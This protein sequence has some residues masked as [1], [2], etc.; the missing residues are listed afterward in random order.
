MAAKP[1][2]ISQFLTAF[3]IKYDA[4]KEA[5]QVPPASSS[6]YNSA[7]L[8]RIG[9][10]STAA[11]S[12]I[13]AMVVG[14]K[15]M[16]SKDAGFDIGTPN[17]VRRIMGDDSYGRGRWFDIKPEHE[18]TV[19]QL[20]VV[21]FLIGEDFAGRAI[22]VPEQNGMSQLEA[23]LFRFH[24][25]VEQLRGTDRSLDMKRTVQDY[26]RIN[27]LPFGTDFLFNATLSQK[28]GSEKPYLAV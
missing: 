3:P 4:Y 27:S 7:V 5:K 12:V 10:E 14:H 18:K 9:Y 22:V 16:W 8:S 25:M 21:G 2:D 23:E 15:Y 19:E 6:V 11:L 13:I 1:S 20:A 24:G 26:C 28:L 17:T